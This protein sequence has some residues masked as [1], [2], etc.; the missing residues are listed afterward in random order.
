[1][2]I[3]TRIQQ[4]IT[5]AFLLLATPS[6]YAVLQLHT[7]L[8]AVSGP[9]TTILDTLGFILPLDSLSLL[10]A[11]P[12]SPFSPDEQALHDPPDRINLLLLGTRGANDPR[13]GLLTDTILIVSIDQSHQRLAL[14]S[15]PRDLYV[16]LSLTNRQHKI[17]AA[18]AIGQT[19]TGSG[20]EFAMDTL[21]RTTGIRIH[22]GV[23]VDML[24]FERLVDMLGGIEVDVQQDFVG[25]TSERLVVR[26]G[27]VRMD[28][29][30]ALAYVTS[31]KSSSDFDRSRRQREV[32]RALRTKAAQLRDPLSLLELLDMLGSHVRT[33]MSPQEIRAF[34]S[35]AQN[36]DY[37]TIIERGFD[38]SASGALTSTRNEQGEYILVP[39][40]GDLTEFQRVF[41]DVFH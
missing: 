31:R 8:R 20:L 16:T 29:P 21:A 41:R 3:R 33:T 7:I 10:N 38:S 13:G 24:A 2:T 40:S 15:V 17:N 5:L 11:S 6:I 23:R 32:V 35:L 1:M 39:R 25:T 34:V 30:T 36:L 28:G 27:R 9:E 26:R 19:H 18:Y 37:S 22:H 14:V 4:I 12:L